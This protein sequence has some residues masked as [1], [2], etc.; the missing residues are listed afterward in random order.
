MEK[1]LLHKY[2]DDTARKYRWLH[3]DKYFNT[4]K[5]IFEKIEI[6]NCLTEKAVMDYKIVFTQNYDLRDFGLY[7]IDFNIA[8]IINLMQKR[9]LE[10][11]AIPNKEVQYDV[12]YHEFPEDFSLNIDYDSKIIVTDF[13][14]NV[15][16]Y[17][18][19]DGNHTFEKNILE[20]NFFDLYYIPFDRLQRN[21]YC[22]DFSYVFH[23]MINEF[24]FVFVNNSH[25]PFRQKKL[26]KYSKIYFFKAELF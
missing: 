13:K 21:C 12:I 22:N 15:C 26:L 8:E 2:I 17:T 19:I 14:T 25:N 10:F 7:F 6:N 24:F 20:N 16:N 4:I 18:M 3:A 23:Y 9:Q 5:Y 1:Y 11:F